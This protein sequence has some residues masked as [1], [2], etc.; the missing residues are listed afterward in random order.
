MKNDSSREHMNRLDVELAVRGLA[1]SRSSALDLI[2]RGKITVNGNVVCKQGLLVKKTDAVV[3]LMRENFV[4]RGGEKIEH[5]LVSWKIDVKGKT[6]IDIGASTGGFT[7]RLLF[8]GAQKV[9]AVDV[10]SDQLDSK[11][12]SDNRVIVMEGVDVR[13]VSLPEIAD[14]AVVDVSFI[15]LSLVLPKI[16]ELIKNAGYVIALVKP[17]FE[18]GRDVAEKNRGI[19]RDERD[20]KPVLEKI[21]KSAR[22]TGF[23]VKAFLDSPI[24]GEHGNREFLILLEK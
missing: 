16:Y 9:Y 15:S 4:G 23:V 12:R 5:A 2:K 21:E 20:R 8:H 6:V 1:R 13:K 3:S 14:M 24:E 17:Q 19:I 7:E 18:V 10:G 11:L 22:E